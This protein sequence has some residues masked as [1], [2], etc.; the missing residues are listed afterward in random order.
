LVSGQ[1]NSVQNGI[2]V[3][4]TGNW[5]RATDFDDSRD[6]SKGTI[7]IITEGTYQDQFWMVTTSG[8]IRPGTT[9][10]SFAV[11][12]PSTSILSLSSGSSLVGF[13][14]A[15]TGAV[16]GTTCN[17]C[18]AGDAGCFRYWITAEGSSSS[19]GS[20]AGSCSLSNAGWSGVTQANLG[21]FTT[22][23]NFRTNNLSK[24][25]AID[26]FD[27]RRQTFIGQ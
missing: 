22:T 17:A 24:N 5:Q 19:E 4:D 12:I 9:A 10:I 7:G 26:E 16:A 27:S 15:G 3:V 6:V 11:G 13:L 1:T 21:L 2:Y 18:A 23:A 25:L 20:P 8:T 14:Q